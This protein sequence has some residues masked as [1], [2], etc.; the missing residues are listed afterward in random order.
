MIRD[1]PNDATLGT[2]FITQ[3]ILRNHQPN[4]NIP[5]LKEMRELSAPTDK[6]D[7]PQLKAWDTIWYTLSPEQKL[8]YK[9]QLP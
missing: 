5:L 8:I 1:R 7:I 4:L 3:D 6:V 2:D 9:N